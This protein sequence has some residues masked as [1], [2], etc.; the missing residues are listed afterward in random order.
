[1]DRAAIQLVAVDPDELDALLPLV[2][3]F[4]AH[5]GYGFEACRKRELLS[6][7]LDDPAAGRLWLI[8]DGDRPIGYLLLA[9]SFSLEMD[10]RIAFVDELFIA[11][12]GRSRGAGARALALAEEACRALGITVLRLEAEADNTRAA[13]LYQRQGYVDLGRRLLSK[14][15]ESPDAAAAP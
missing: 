12:E 2:E 9:F 14:P 13:A 8:H 10:G 6:G 3:A 5:F 1:M 11:P 7:L 15:L 4:Y